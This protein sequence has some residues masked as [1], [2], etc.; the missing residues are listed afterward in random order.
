MTVCFRELHSLTTERRRAVT[1][2]HTEYHAIW[3]TAL[4]EGVATGVFVPTAKVVLKGL[5]GM[6]FHSFLWLDPRGV[7]NAADIG[8]TFADIVLNTV[9]K[10]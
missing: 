5:L 1:G 2:L 10:K 4:S 7:Q 9:L 6:Y 8:N 3:S